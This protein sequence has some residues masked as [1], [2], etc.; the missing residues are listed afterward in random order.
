VARDSGSRETRNGEAS[1]EQ[2][3][4]VISGLGPTEL[5]DMLQCLL[6]SRMPLDGLLRAA[7]AASAAAATER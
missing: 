6:A 3:Q 1:W 4:A 7:S 2:I 5:K